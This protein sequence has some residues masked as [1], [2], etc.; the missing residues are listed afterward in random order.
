MSR[1]AVG[2]RAPG[3]VSEDSRES[4]KT[5]PGEHCI[6]VIAWKVSKLSLLKLPIKH[7]VKSM[8]YRYSC[9]KIIVGYSSSP[10]CWT[11]KGTTG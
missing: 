7:L 1:T 2:G 5:D 6:S 4:R 3:T 9:N 11:F 10:E 8:W